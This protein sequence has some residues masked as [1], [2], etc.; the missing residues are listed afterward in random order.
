MGQSCTALPDGRVVCIAGEHEDYYDPDFYIYNDVVVLNPDGAIASYGYPRDAFPPT[1]FHTATL[2]AGRLVIVGV[3]GYPDDRIPG[4]TPVYAL[5]LASYRIDRLDTAGEMP[6]WTCRHRAKLDAGR[7]VIKVRRGE[8]LVERSGDRRFRRNVEEYELDLGALVWR[9]TTDR[10]WP[11]FAI[12]PADGTLITYPHS[13]DFEDFRPAE[14]PHEVVPRDGRDS[15]LSVHGITVRFN[16]NMVEAEVLI[17][18]KLPAE[19]V[20]ELLEQTRRYVEA[21]TG[22]ACVVAAS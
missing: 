17:E 16:A 4:H 20:T 15:R 6:G 9:R 2:D 12:R 8:A 5:D 10:N 19:T 3:I 21:A 22:R 7:R 13:P 11:Q 14:V 1:D 18:G